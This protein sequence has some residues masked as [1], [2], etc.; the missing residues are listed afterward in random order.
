MT[1]LFQGVRAASLAGIT[2]LAGSRWNSSVIVEGY[3]GRADEKPWVDFNNVSPGY[4]ETLGIP[5]LLGRDF[6]PEDN[7][8]FTPDP[9]PRPG[10]NEEGFGPPAPVAIVNEAFAKHY[11]TGQNPVGHHFTQG[12]KID[13]K[14][15][16]EIVGVVKDAKYFNIRKTVDPMIYV[17]VWRFGSQSV[18]L[19]IR[20]TGRPEQL[21]AS[22]RHETAN[23]D[24]AIPLLQT[25][26]LETQFD[27]TIA[28]ELAVTTLR[29]FFVMSAVLLAAMGLA[30]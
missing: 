30:V 15:S 22:V 12:D 9:K 3:N 2:P 23:I 1:L 19:C 17:P 14:R 20:S 7:P 4:F 28:Q 10:K 25:L 11:F 29:G 6:R 5:M 21:V 24:P 13:A 27:K 18:A 8:A 26:T 16:F